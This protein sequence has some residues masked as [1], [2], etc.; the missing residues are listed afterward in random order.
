MTYTSMES[1]PQEILETSRSPFY[2][3]EFRRFNWTLIFLELILVGVGL[4][5][6][7]SATGVQDKSLGLY[8]SQLI[9]FGAGSL[10][11][12][13]VLLIHYS[14]LNRLAYVIYFANLLLLVAVLFIGRTTLGA[15]RWLSIGGFG[16]QPSEF[17]KIS[18]VICLAKYFEA[19]KNLG[20]LSLK[21]MVLPSL[22]VMIPVGLI[23]LQPDLGTAMM[24]CLTF[25]SM[26]LFV[27]IQPKTLLIL[28]TPRRSRF[29]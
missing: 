24:I 23:I 26:L 15:K 7:T 14:V 2:E 28:L 16:M 20:G 13:L 10:L 21:E 22:L 8:K 9:W 6:L 17:M 1:P 3:E 18:I 27:R 12:A 19:E 29:P 4:W 5:N 11:T 25:L